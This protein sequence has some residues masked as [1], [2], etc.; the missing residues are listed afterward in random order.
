MSAHSSAVEDCR[1]VAIADPAALLV[2]RFDQWIGDIEGHIGDLEEQICEL[3][4]MGE[5]FAQESFNLQ[6]LDL[7]LEIA[8][9]AK[10]RM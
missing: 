1:S 10:A 3:W 5:D 2:R 6:K 9:E 7:L 4:L 8:R